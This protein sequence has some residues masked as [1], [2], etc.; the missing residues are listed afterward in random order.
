MVTIHTGE[1]SEPIWWIGGGQSDS[2]VG[3]SPM[4][5]YP[6]SG[7]WT[8]GQYYR[9]KF[10]GSFS[11]ILKKKITFVEKKIPPPSKSEMA[12]FLVKVL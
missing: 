10:Q 11:Q 7:K 5:Q 1:R 6:K 4:S 2:T 8:G 9:S 12:T 3:P